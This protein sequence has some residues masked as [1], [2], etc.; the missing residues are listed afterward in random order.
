MSIAVSSS[1][2]A[3][4]GDRSTGELLPVL[5]DP[6]DRGT[7]SL[8]DRVVQR[9]AGHA[10][11]LVDGAGAAP[12]RVLGITVGESRADGEA[13]VDARIDGRTATIDATVAIAW[14]ASVGAVTSRLRDRIRQDVE[15]LTG[16]RVDHIDIDVVSMSAPAARPRRVL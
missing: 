1:E 10:V 16:V 5:E 8:D 15:R 6:A 11:T 7:L 9:V 14:P 4:P 13:S 12:R 3:A 2:E